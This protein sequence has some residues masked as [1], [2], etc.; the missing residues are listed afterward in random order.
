MALPLGA[1]SEAEMMEIV[2]T[3]KMN[4][5]EVRAKL[6]E[7]LP[8]GMRLTEVEDLPVKYLNGRYMVR[9]PFDCFFFPLDARNAARLAF[10]PPPAGMTIPFSTN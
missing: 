5:E 3:E 8:A 10:V 4:A 7:Q 9:F 2:L 6:D 1:S